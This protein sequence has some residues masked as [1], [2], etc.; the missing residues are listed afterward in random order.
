MAALGSVQK[1]CTN[2]RVV[3]A[4]LWFVSCLV[5]SC[6]IIKYSLFKK[7]TSVQMLSYFVLNVDS[8]VLDVYNKVTSGK[9]GSTR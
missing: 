6:H 9:K 8:T 1:Q 7:N 5:L 2:S 4:F 3:F